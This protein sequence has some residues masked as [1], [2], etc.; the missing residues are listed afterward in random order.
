MM[1]L[2]SVNNK[3]VDEIEELPGDFYEGPDSEY[4][5]YFRNGKSGVFGPYTDPFGTLVTGAVPIINKNNG[6][7]LA[8]FGM[9]VTA[10]YW[11]KGIKINRLRDIEILALVEIILVIVL[12]FTFGM[13]QALN[14]VKQSEEK[15]KEKLAELEKI[16]KLMVGRELKMIELKK[17]IKEQCKV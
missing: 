4:K 7:I 2:A 6:Q 5:D 12:G 14:K 8:L 17:Q 1:F 16:N 10:Q 3:G 13:D 9:D 11:E 15:I